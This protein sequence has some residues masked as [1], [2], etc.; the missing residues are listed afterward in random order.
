MKFTPLLQINFRGFNRTIYSKNIKFM[1][2]RPESPY[3]HLVSNPKLCL[4][5]FY[6]ESFNE[7][8]RY[9]MA[10]PQS[11]NGSPISEVSSIFSSTGKLI[12]TLSVNGELVE[13]ICSEIIN[14]QFVGIGGL[15]YSHHIFRDLQ[16]LNPISN[17]NL[18]FCE[19]EETN[20]GMHYYQ[21]LGKVQI[22]KDWGYAQS[23]GPYTEQGVENQTQNINSDI[24]GEAMRYFASSRTLN[25]SIHIIDLSVRIELS[26]DKISHRRGDH[27]GGFEHDLITYSA[28]ASKLFASKYDL[29]QYLDKLAQ[30]GYNIDENNKEPVFYTVN[31]TIYQLSQEFNIKFSY[32][33]SS[34]TESCD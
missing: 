31:K 24:Y 3:S 6:I 11:I 21:L 25:F 13:A 8:G 5:N 26:E 19:K 23:I 2:N 27:D 10:T 22:I 14:S 32:Q 30:Y 7:N 9:W 29:R 28:F 34:Y 15:L 16:F 18:I 33:Y 1:D 12:I 20:G 4:N 17:Q